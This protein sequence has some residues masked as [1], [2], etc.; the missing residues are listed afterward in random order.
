MLHTEAKMSL[1]GVTM[2]SKFESHTV[3]SVRR[4]DYYITQALTYK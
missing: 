1:T 2:L 3:S 4:Q